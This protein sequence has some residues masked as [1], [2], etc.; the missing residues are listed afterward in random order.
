MM[1]CLFAGKQG[2]GMS[3]QVHSAGSRQLAQKASNGAIDIPQK[4]T[5]AVVSNGK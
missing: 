1:A 5:S 2:P 3:T 4:L